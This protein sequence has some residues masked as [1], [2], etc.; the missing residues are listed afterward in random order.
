ME[1]E[2]IKI[3]IDSNDDVLEAL[4]LK[5]HGFKF[6]IEKINFEKVD[7]NTLPELS[8]PAWEELA[9]EAFKNH[10]HINN[11]NIR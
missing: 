7:K 9:F 10:G 8:R 5:K 4:K 6:K 3:S 11:S 1:Q 2:K